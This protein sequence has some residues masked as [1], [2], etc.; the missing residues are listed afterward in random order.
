M[1]V[2]RLQRTSLVMLLVLLLGAVAAPAAVNLSLTPAARSG[3]GSNTVMFAG[4]FTNTDTVS[5][6]FLNRIQFTFT[7]QA[8]N[9]LAGDTNSFYANVPGILSP[10]ENYADAVFAIN[11][12][13]VTPSGSYT[14]AVTVLGGTNIF[15]S[16]TLAS[17]SF[18][19]LLTSTPLNI[20]RNGT[21]LILSWPSPP[22]NF[23]V[24]QIV[25]LTKTNW[26]TLTNVPVVTN[27][28]SRVVLLMSPMPT[29]QF[30]R[31][32]DP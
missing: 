28:N 13:P 31:L 2:M 24:Q 12:S 20:Q 11:V 19:V 6:A 21:N 22:T 23:V 30:F 8:T 3:V 4:S 29:N 17:Q 1:N 18:Q 16:N 7:G 5:N 26:I 10:L 27:G 14:G 9:Y 15:A 25:K 32:V